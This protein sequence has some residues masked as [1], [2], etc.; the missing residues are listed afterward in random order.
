MRKGDTGM[1]AYAVTG[2]QWGDEGKGKIVD[3]L[4]EKMEAVVRF[5]GG[6]NAGHTIVIGGR[7][8][9]LHTIPSGIF[10]AGMLN[11]IGNGVVLDPEEFLTEVDGLTAGGIAIDPRSLK[12]SRR[13]SIIMDYHRVIDKARESSKS[14]ETKI[15][16]TGR[17]IGPAYEDKSSRFGVRAADLL[18]PDR[19]KERISHAVAEKN[20]LLKH[21]YGAKESIDLDA[22]VEKYS[23]IGERL[24]PF[25]VDD[26]Q[27]FL[28][29]F[30]GKKIL[31]EGAQGSMLDI[32]FG[33]F[34]FVTSS[35][36]VS[37]YAFVG[38]GI[39]PGGLAENIAVLKAYTTRVGGGPFPTQDPG[40]A[41]RIMVQK[42]MEFGA[43]TGR[44]RR[45]G[46]LDLVALRSTFL[47]NRFTAIALT[48][49]D[50]LSGFKTLKVATA[51][52]VNGVETPHFP[53]DIARLAAA[54]PVYRELPG[55][56]ADLSAIRK[57]SDLPS[58]TRDY[59]AFIEDALSTPVPIVSVGPGRDQI[60]FTRPIG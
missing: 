1:L 28:A 54:E 56:T 18:S 33:T 41:G 8:H 4:A 51:Y 15:G 55:W 59:I 42:G 7:K 32:D 17:G 34:P 60:L 58:E 23:R 27:A 39:N 19:L 25:I 36:T 14:A 13:A 49:I 26:E 48:K 46:W 12:I 11:F 21:L 53:T 37:S 9:V 44:E 22:T 24:A 35:N 40:E 2:A 10:H 57:F 52:R 29:S 47:V 20:A 3:V 45:C 50:V 43:T 38:S 31:F 6:N 30:A 16:T 5:Q